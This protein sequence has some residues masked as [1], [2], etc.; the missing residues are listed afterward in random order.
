MRSVPCSSTARKQIE[1]GVLTTKCPRCSQVPPRS[2]PSHPKK[3]AETEAERETEMGT[4][5]ET[6]TDT[7]TDTD[8]ESPLLLI[9]G[10]TAVCCCAQAYHDFQGCTAL[11]CSRCSCH[12]CGWCLRDCAG[13]KD[14][15]DHVRACPERPP[16]ADIFYP[17]PWSIFEHHWLTKKA[18]KV[19][20]ALRSLTAQE[21][22]ELQ[23][24]MRAQLAGLGGLGLPP[25]NGNGQAPLDAVPE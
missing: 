15:H 14:C 18:G 12:F 11:A 3:G 16:S 23:H 19:R 6:E 20:K 2:N 25:D 21:R 1:E 9:G 10:S 4:E 8:T 24:D 17:R 13:S 5:T 22:R 7:D